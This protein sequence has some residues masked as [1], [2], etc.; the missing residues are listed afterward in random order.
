MLLD[1][2]KVRLGLAQARR[3]RDTQLHIAALLLHL[4][5]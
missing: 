5:T 2:R 3:L 1:L 4:R